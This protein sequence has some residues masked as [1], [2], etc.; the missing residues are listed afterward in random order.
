MLKEKMSPHLFFFFRNFIRPK[1]IFQKIAQHRMFSTPSMKLTA[2]PTRRYSDIEECT[3]HDA[4]RRRNAFLRFF[5][6]PAIEC[7]ALRDAMKKLLLLLTV[8]STLSGGE[9][10]ASFEEFLKL[11]TSLA[12]KEKLDSDY[13]PGI[14][15][16]LRQ[17]DLRLLGAASVPEALQF[18]PGFSNNENVRGI[19]G[20]GGV[21]GRGKKLFMVNGVPLNTTV[22][23]RALYYVPI[24][25]VDRIE[26]LRGPGSSLYGGYAFTAVINIITLKETDQLFGRYLQYSERNNGGEIGGQGFVKE[27]SWQ[28]NLYAA[29]LDTQGEEL[30]GTDRAGRFGSI[31]MVQKNTFLSAD[32]T[33]GDF[34]LNLQYHSTKDGE[35]YGF[36]DFL[37]PNDGRPSSFSSTFTAEASYASDI[38]DVL[39]LD[40]KA[41]Y[42]HYDFDLK[43]LHLIPNDIFS[44]PIYSETWGAMGE[45]HYREYKVYGQLETH[46][47]F[48]AHNLLAGA[49]LSHADMISNHSCRN[50]AKSDP[51]DSLYPL[52]NPLA[53][54]GCVSGEESLIDV[55]EPR[56]HM[57]LY[58][59]DSIDAGND[60]HFTL[61]VRYD[62][63]SDIGDAWSPRL[64][65]VYHLSSEHIFKAQ[66]AHAFRPPTFSELYYSYNP[67]IEGNSAL[68]PE[69][70]DTVELGYIY[71]KNENIFRATLFYT[72]LDNMILIEESEGTKRPENIGEAYSAG[73][74]LEY[75]TDLY[76]ILQFN[77]NLTLNKTEDRET[78]EPLPGSADISGNAA[79][80]L[81]PY[82]K[83]NASLWYHYWGAKHRDSSDPGET[84]TDT[85][86]ANQIDLLCN[87]YPLHNRTT[88]LIQGG[89]KNIFNEYISRPS[90]SGTYADDYPLM[91]ERTFWGSLAYHF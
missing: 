37:P 1:I 9:K 81:M 91:Q 76:D 7:F 69:K 28:L 50:W 16:I 14:I 6:L 64:A 8:I 39:T 66:Y 5:R 65:A 4:W 47:R 58:L 84:R 10:P 68:T 11:Q 61:G 40:A 22:D 86:P 53:E 89:V 12:S 48:D 46:Y 26:V 54:Y 55:P 52:P 80:T 19:G 87:I 72:L 42:F 2:L 49:E 71:Q 36:V 18:V 67:A 27:K 30:Y 56:N 70:L 43:E 41:G 62:H 25:M 31:E 73:M 75:I 15:S 20:L 57:A 63:F 60:L 90:P 83:Y 38:T 33:Y 44:V 59:Q 51:G 21:F 3:R 78:K 45:N 79:L 82:A 35:Q 74:E 88:L 85:D 13:A 17:E 77:G 24:H 29:Y 32:L 34:A 23:G